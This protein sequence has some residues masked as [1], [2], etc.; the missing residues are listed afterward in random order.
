MPSPSIK[1]QAGKSLDMELHVPPSAMD[2][3][4][5]NVDEVAVRAYELWQER[6]CPIGSPEI[7]WLRAEEDL[8]NRTRSIQTAA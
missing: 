6:G 1:E 7:D 2:S 5:V 8:R 4:L 3:E